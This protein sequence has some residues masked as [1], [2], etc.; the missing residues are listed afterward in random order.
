MNICRGA[1]GTSTIA[2]RYAEPFK[3]WIGQGNPLNLWILVEKFKLKGCRFVVD[4]PFTLE[5]P[6]RLLEQGQ[7]F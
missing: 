6:A 7:A 1:A 4:Q 2:S 5:T 3:F